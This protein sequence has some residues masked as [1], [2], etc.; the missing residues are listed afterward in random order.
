MSDKSRM[1]PALVEFLAE[2]TGEPA[3]TLNQ[4]ARR[5]REAGYLSQAGHGRAGAKA[6]SRDAATILLVSMGTSTAIHAS[7]VVEAL[8]ALERQ[9]GEKFPGWEFPEKLAGLDVEA[10]D[11]IGAV[12]EII[13]ALRRRDENFEGIVHVAMSTS[14][15]PHVTIDWSTSDDPRYWSFSAP[16]K[17]EALARYR[18][19]AH[20]SGTVGVPPII[21]Y[22]TAES[23]ILVALADWFE[24]R[25]IG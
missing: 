2:I 20:Q 21:R 4:I 15:D 7:P 25:E 14:G 10:T 11:P 19:V 13:D 1:V 22:V 9:V 16:E 18:K 8:S 5:T 6:T 17:S 3:S 24:G 23:W 12:A